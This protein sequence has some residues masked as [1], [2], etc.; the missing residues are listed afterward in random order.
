LPDRKNPLDV[1]PDLDEVARLLDPLRFEIKLTGAVDT[2]SG[3]GSPGPPV[4]EAART[5]LASRGFKAKVKALMGSDICSACGM[6]HYE[7]MSVEP[8]RW[9]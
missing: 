4:F 5:F 1:L 2:G 8:R 9:A 7:D 6:L 3:L